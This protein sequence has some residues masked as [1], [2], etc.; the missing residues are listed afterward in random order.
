MGFIPVLKYLNLRSHQNIVFFDILNTK[1]FSPKII[2]AWE[3]SNVF[4]RDVAFTL[5]IHGLALQ[6]CHHSGAC[7]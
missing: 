1:I 6:F 3:W 4:L 5:K 7:I 2:S